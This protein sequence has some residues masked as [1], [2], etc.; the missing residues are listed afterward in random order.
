[1]IECYYKQCENHCKDKPFCALATCNA[2]D[3]KLE[4]LQKIREK[5]CQSVE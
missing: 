2:S 4:I 1:M 3:K 5:E